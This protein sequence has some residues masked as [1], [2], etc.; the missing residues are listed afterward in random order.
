MPDNRE[1][2]SNAP[3]ISSNGPVDNIAEKAEELRDIKIESKEEGGESKEYP[4]RP[5][6][7]NCLFYLKNGMCGYGSNCRFNHPPLSAMTN[8][9]RSELPQREGQPEC[10]Y[11]MK[12]GCCKYGSTCKYSHP[13]D[14]HGAGQVQFNT[15][16]LPI[17]QEE[18]SCP[19]YLRNYTCKFGS[20]CKFN[21]PEPASSLPVFGPAATTGTTMGS[22]LPSHFI[23][24]G[25]P[26]QAWSVT[27]S[28]YM[29][30]SQVPFQPTFV[31]LGFPSLQGPFVTQSW[32]GYMGNLNVVS[33]TAN[34]MTI[35]NLPER[36]DQPACRYFLSTGT[37]RYGPNCKFHHPKERIAHLAM[38]TLGP[39]GLPLRPG[40]DICAHFSSY[41]IC[42]FGPRCKFNHPIG[43]FGMSEPIA[44]NSFFPSQRN[45]VTTNSSETSQSKSF[46]ITDWIQKPEPENV[47][48]KNQ[49]KDVK[50]IKDSTEPVDHQLDIVPTTSE[51]LQNQAE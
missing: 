44:D 20:S 42:K 25:G 28:P 27:R 8:Q 13:L 4:E 37:C 21:H 5:G 9:N 17:R 19:Y 26:L 48:D 30:S 32:N 36:S 47:E 35:P 18:K 7:P 16:G 49:N 50:T 24:Y 45:P 12:T 31:P 10:G 29:A 39:H 6:E 22:Y 14:R 11:Y 15:L 3:S 2:Q 41:G 43:Y 34:T 51:V 33:A 46:E 38:N 23:P 40:E 1:N